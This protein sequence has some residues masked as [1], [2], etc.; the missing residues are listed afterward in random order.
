MLDIL[1]NAEN[2]LDVTLV[3]LHLRYQDYIEYLS[4]RGAKLAPDNYFPRALDYYYNKYQVGSIKSA[5]GLVNDHIE[6][7]MHYKLRSKLSFRMLCFIL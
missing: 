1:K 4:Q 6:S 3:S 7:V 2:K 5:L